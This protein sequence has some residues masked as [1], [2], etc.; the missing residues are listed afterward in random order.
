MDTASFDSL[1]TPRYRRH[2]KRQRTYH[3]RILGTLSLSLLL[4]SLFARL[5]LPDVPSRVG[6]SSSPVLEP[7]Q[8]K[9]VRLEEASSPIAGAP[10]TTFSTTREPGETG[11]QQ[12]EK[13]N[14][15]ASAASSG[16]NASQPYL[17]SKLRLRATQTL[18]EVQGGM[19]SYYLNIT[20]PRGAIRQGIQGRLTLA[21]TVEKNG[22]PTDIRVTKSLHP[23][24]DSAAVRA[25]RKTVFVPGRRGGDKVRMRMRLPVR[26]KLVNSTAASQ[27]D[28]VPSP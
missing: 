7:L 21:F 1:F 20:Y 15:G 6:W 26:F 17:S 5:P 14:T 19:K 18:P 12:D 3:L 24:C 4:L 11:R 28:R 8:L 16:T 23:L 9:D 10:I 25:L 22:R 27:K 2:I 13:R